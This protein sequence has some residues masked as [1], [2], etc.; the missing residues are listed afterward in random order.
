MQELVALEEQGWKALS[1]EPGDGQAFYRSTLRDDAIMLF[2]G[3]M[4]LVGKEAIL[5]AIASQPWESY[6]MSEV[7]AIALS[8]ESGVV[9]YS[10]TA[11]RADMEPY[12]ALISSTY[13][14]TKGEWKLVIHQQTPS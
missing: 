14:L 11:R 4:K 12:V 1:S 3:G 6:E 10:V 2:P 7:E 8:K 13:A 5:S 9:V